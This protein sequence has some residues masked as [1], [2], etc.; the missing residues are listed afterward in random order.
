MENK[1]S[2]SVYR[3]RFTLDPGDALEAGVRV[4]RSTNIP[5]EAASEETIVGVDRANGGIFID[6]SHSGK[7]D[8]SPEFAERMWAPLKHAQTAGV[9]IELVMDRNSI[10][11]FAEDGETVLS[12]L[13][14]PA[15]TSQGLA[16]YSTTLPPGTAPAR[17]R[18]L[19][20]TPLDGPI[21]KK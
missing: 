1:L 17:V 14:Y 9:P 6:R 21:G 10:E 5:N 18:N 8:W 20:M 7:I 19:E 11:V 16:F 2:G 15:A 4:R 13:I 12:A 3:L